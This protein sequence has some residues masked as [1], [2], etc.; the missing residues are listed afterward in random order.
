MMPP[1]AEQAVNPNPFV[2]RAEAP[3]GKD[4]GVSVST[5]GKWFWTDYS[6][7][8]AVRP[9]MRDLNAPLVVAL[10]AYRPQSGGGHHGRRGFQNAASFFARWQQSAR[11]KPAVAAFAQ[12]VACAV[13]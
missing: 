6:V 4:S 10:G 9:T 5:V 3:K 12:S 8:A 2:F 1:K 7:S 13:P 11:S